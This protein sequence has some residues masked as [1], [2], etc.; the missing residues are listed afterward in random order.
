MM[1]DD[2]PYVLERIDALGGLLDL[3]TNDLGNEFRGKLS[4]GAA[5]GFALDDVGHLAANGPD[6]RGRSVG[7][8]LD[9]VGTALGE[10][11]GEQTDEVVVGSLH[12]HIRLNQSLPLPHQRAQFVGGEV[13]SVEVRQAVLSLDLIDSQA[14]L[15]EGVILVLLQIGQR[16]LNNPSLQSIVRVLQTGRAVHQGLADTRSFVRSAGCNMVAFVF[17][18]F[19]LTL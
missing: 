12:G 19:G 14:D 16:D 13:K 8:L 10:G 2:D 15:T 3:A 6:L 5:G 1:K 4:E 9:L 7:G 11:D 17:I 18:D